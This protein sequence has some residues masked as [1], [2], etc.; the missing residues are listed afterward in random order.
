M[1]KIYET[2][3]ISAVDTFVSAFV[4]SFGPLVASSTWSTGTWHAV[5]T[6]IALV[7]VR[8]AWKSTRQ[9]ISGNPINGTPSLVAA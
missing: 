5:L 4:L 7:A 9:W 6:S 1:N 2:Y 8:Q 3:V